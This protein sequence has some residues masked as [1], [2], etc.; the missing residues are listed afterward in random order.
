MKNNPA[1]VSNRK[2][3]VGIDIDR[4]F[5]FSKDFFR[6]IEFVS[7]QDEDVIRHSAHDHCNRRV[8]MRTL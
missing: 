1:S 4:C 6:F 7:C 2:R 3:F 5:L 8:V